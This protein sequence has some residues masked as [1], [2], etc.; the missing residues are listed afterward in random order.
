[1]KIK[2]KIIKYTYENS[3]KEINEENLNYKKNFDLYI[4][5]VID[6]SH[7]LVKFSFKLTINLLIFTYLILFLFLL[8]KKKEEKVFKFILRKIEKFFFFNKTLKLIKIYSII[9]YYG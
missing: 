6:N 1:M 4:E 3:I 8:N 7:A 9:Y 5:E 2:S